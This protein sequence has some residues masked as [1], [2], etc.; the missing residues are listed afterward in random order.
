MLTELREYDAALL[1]KPRVLVANKS[2]IPES[3]EGIEALDKNRDEAMYT[4]SAAAGTGVP[5]LMKA[6]GEL[7]QGA[8]RELAERP[9]KEIEAA[10]RYVYVAPWTVNAFDGGFAITGKKVERLAAMTDWENE[11]AQRYFMENLRKLGLLRALARN[12][13]K[14]GDVVQIG[15]V[16]FEYVTDE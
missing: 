7:V 15:T 5:D 13:A 4:I 16:E 12:G 8:R 11:E 14:T 2:D 1:D 10:R 3:A 9:R 6:L